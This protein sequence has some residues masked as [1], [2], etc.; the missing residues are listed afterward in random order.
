MKRTIFTAILVAVV[1]VTVT[2]SLTY[3]QET[4]KE[5]QR[6]AEQELL[7]LEKEWYDAFLRRSSVAE[8]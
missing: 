6:R 8:R 1:L 4:N 2:S 3:S 7:T 5:N